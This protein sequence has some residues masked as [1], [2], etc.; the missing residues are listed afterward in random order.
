MFPSSVDIAGQASVPCIYQHTFD[1]FGLRGSVDID[2]EWS[3]LASIAVGVSR[4]Q[5]D[6]TLLFYCR[7]RL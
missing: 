6:L 2:L 3:Q 7:L 5:R 4:V 1:S